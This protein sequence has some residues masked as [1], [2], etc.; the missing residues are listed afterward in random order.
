V[1]ANEYQRQALRTAATLSGRDER[2]LNAAMGLAGEAG[3]F[4]E[5]LKKSRFHGH[6]LDEAALHKE[7]GDVLWYCSLAAAALGATLGEVM[8]GNLDKLRRRYPNGFSSVDSLRRV[9]EEGV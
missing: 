1:D 2:L 5:A 7:L 6:V 3:E 9:D 4:I 8:Q